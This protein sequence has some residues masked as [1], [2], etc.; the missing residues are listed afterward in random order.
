MD[1]EIPDLFTD[2]L[3][4]SFRHT[5][6]TPG[7]RDCYNPSLNATGTVVAFATD[8]DYFGQNIPQYQF[9]VWLYDTVAM[10]LTRVTYASDSDRASDRTTVSADGSLVAFQSDSDFLGDGIP[11]N[12]FEVWLYNTATMTYTR[13]TIGSDTDRDT[14]RPSLSE[15]WIARLGHR[16][17]LP[18]VLK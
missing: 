10:T 11:N 16:V 13:V 8:A 2:C 18:L 6:A 3:M 14:I 1:K 17:Y 4:N 7:N 15:I 5:T 12:Q 9:E